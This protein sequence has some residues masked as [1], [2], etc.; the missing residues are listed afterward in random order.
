MYEQFFGLEEEPF[1]LTPDPRYL[2]LS[3]KHAEALA[4]L[5]LCLTESSGFVCITG[6]VGTGKTTLLRLFL[7]ELGPNVSSAYTFV[8][9]L[10]AVE[11]LRRICREFKLPVADQTQD[12]LVEQLHQFLM[13][14]YREGRMCVLILDEAQ[15]L[16]IELLEQIRL[17]LNLETNTQKL[18]RIVLVGQP[19]LRKLLLDP[20]L[21]QLN[22]R[23]T[24]RWH[25]GPLSARQTTGYITHRLTVASGGRGTHVF[26]RPALRLIHHISGGVPRLI[27]MIAH[28]AL[29]AAFVE[30]EPR[31]TRRTISRAYK[32]IQSVPLPGTLSMPRRAIFA[33]VGLAVGALLVVM[34]GPQLDWLQPRLSEAMRGVSRLNPGRVS[35]AISAPVV[36]APAVEQV[37]VALAE[38]RPRA[39]PAADVAPALVREIAPAAA[40]PSELAGEAHPDAALAP[41]TMPAEP[42]PAETAA[43]AQTAWQVTTRLGTGLDASKPMS[44]TDLSRT[45]TSTGVE[46]TA[47]A[48]TDGILAAWG[49]HPLAANETQLPDELETVAMRRGLLDVGLTG[50]RSMLRLL[51]LPA[52]L[53]L[54]FPGST[55]PRFVALLGM[56]GTQAVLSIGGATTTV[57]AAALDRIWS[58]QAHVLWRDF[59]GIGGNLSRGAR[60]VVVTRLQQLL[61]R[62][63]VYHA[64]PSGVFDADTRAAVVQFQRSNQL[65]EDG[66][67]GPLT[68]IVLYRTA[69][70][71]PRPT[72][73]A[74]TQGAT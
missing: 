7:S 45:V 22:Q 5:K 26:T 34:G 54:R 61:Q 53:T 8:P 57:E 40:A 36:G 47:R 12:E 31:I 46:G 60:G 49:E 25:L 32:E 39:E 65:A 38:E 50:N 3:T 2:F 62:A 27:N 30:R 59:D 73:A 15:A 13:A 51:D 19:Q 42:P 17:L 66:I 1:R 70:G 48:A 52:V 41:P 20:D 43:P 37:K 11:L 23:I 35:A 28:R 44:D 68:R 10:S 14:Q 58:G 63:G 71:Y 56:D 74:A 4:H 16:S 33:T 18:L 55:T 29:L 67:V 21:A 64:R 9:P 69:G 24:L 6:D 72:L